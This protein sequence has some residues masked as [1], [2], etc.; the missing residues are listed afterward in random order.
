[1]SVYFTTVKT[2]LQDNETC[3]HKILTV[4]KLDALH[5]G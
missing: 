1:M 2:Q 3:R 5:N 4:N